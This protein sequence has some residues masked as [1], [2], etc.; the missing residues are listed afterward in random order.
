M[1]S[2]FGLLD[3]VPKITNWSNESNQSDTSLEYPNFEDQIRFD[4]IDFSYATRPDVKVLN[5]FTATIRKGETVAL[6]G[7]SGCG[8]YILIFHLYMN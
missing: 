8:D 1:T 6:V 7:S 5:K 4:R 2:L 3:R